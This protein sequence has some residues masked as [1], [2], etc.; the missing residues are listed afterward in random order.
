MSSSVIG[1]VIS[2]PVWIYQLW[3]FITPGLTSKERRYTLGY[4]AAA[5][6]LLT[7][8]A[9]NTLGAKRVVIRC[10]ERNTRSANVARRLG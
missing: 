6:R 9:L 2:S 8:Y 7:D 10:D 3:A 5:V 4:M 1:L